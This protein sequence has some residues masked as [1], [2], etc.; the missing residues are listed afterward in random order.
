MHG[1]AVAS[2]PR[3]SES[4]GCP[5]RPRSIDDAFWI[6][7]RDQQVGSKWEV[8]GKSQKYQP[9]RVSYTLLGLEVN[10]QMTVVLRTLRLAMSR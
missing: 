5:V 7:N 8:S 9:F 1:C 3:K 2:I 6:L 10:L 4:K